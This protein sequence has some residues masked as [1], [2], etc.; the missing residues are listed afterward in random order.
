MKRIDELEDLKETFNLNEREFE[1]LKE[2]KA[3]EYKI[4]DY[5]T[6]LGIGHVDLK[7]YLADG[8]KGGASR[9]LSV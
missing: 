5:I 3:K 4:L 9:S 1:L 7:T 6:S 2:K 8:S